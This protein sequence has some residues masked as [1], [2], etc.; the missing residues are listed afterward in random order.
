MG[1]NKSIQ[2]ELSAIV[3]D[4]LSLAGNTINKDYC[5]QEITSHTDYPALTA[6][7]DF[8]D[9]GNMGYGAVQADASHIHEM[10]YPVLAH[11]KLPGNEYLHIIPNAQA[12]EADKELTQHWSGISIFP[13]KQA[14]F[15]SKE[16]T[17]AIKAQHSKQYLFIAYCVAGLALF[18]AS[19]WYNPLLWFNVFGFLS[20]CGVAVSLAA[21][22]TELGIQ[23]TAIK[24]V[25]GAVSKSGCN[26]VLKSKLAKGIWG[27][28]PGD[29]AVVYFMAQFTIYVVSV[30]YPTLF[31]LLPILAFAGIAL[32][33]LSLYTQ[34]F[35]IKQWCALCLGIALVLV[36]QAATALALVTNPTLSSS[37]ALLALSAFYML[38]LLPIKSLLKANLSAKPKLTELKKWQNDANLFAAQLEKEQQVDTSIWEN[39]LIIGNSNAPVMITVA[40]NPY[41]GPCAKAHVELDNLVEKYPNTVKVQVR[42]L[43]DP[44]NLEEQRTKAVHA[45][46]GYAETNPAATAHVLTDWFAD[47]NYYKWRNKYPEINLNGSAEMVH[48]KIKLHSSWVKDAGITAT[49]TFFVNGKKLPGRYNLKNI[50]KIIPAMVD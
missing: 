15:V 23:S 36:L 38:I 45:M 34:A 20:L 7:V 41:C 22:A 25:C 1:K 17:A 26:A 42:F 10:N 14:S 31:S 28:T 37:I 32:V 2:K 6:V 13:Q 48:E 9:E 8:L 39:D 35:V 33:A 18:A 29:A 5:Q 49:P 30:F 19:V 12:W 21:F 4:W 11:I 50:E 40:C 27:F 43:C 16:N 44:K 3:H 46:L 24:Q 47:M